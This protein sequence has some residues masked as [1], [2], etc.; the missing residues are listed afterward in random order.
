MENRFTNRAQKVLALAASSAHQW[1][2]TTI[3]TDHLLFGL[4]MEGSGIAANVL[5]LAG[6]TLANLESEM[7][8]TSFRVLGSDQRETLAYSPRCKSAFV[9]ASAFATLM[10][11]NY[12]GTEHL[13]LGV[14]EEPHG[15]SM[16]L[17]GNLGIDPKE[18]KEEVFNL[19]G[20][21]KPKPK[22]ERSIQEECDSLRGIVEDIK[23]ALH[24]EDDKEILSKI[25]QI[26]KDS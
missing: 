11:H 18:M 26:L 16:Q 12:V 3:S 15:I 24:E 19:L 9:A 25:H 14:L 10:Q 17:L 5:K 23:E 4:F 21:E 7:E 20:Y 6:I 1:G 22:E 8:K 13:L 2:H